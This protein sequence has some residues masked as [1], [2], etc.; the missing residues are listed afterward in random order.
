MNKTKKGNNAERE[1]KQYLEALGL[2]VEQAKSQIVMIGKNKFFRRSYDFWNLFDLIALGQSWLRLIQVKS[3]ISDV[4]RAKKLITKFVNEN[5]C[6]YTSVEIW[7][8]VNGK[9]DKRGAGFRI[10]TFNSHWQE[11]EFVKL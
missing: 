7:L 2:P 5:P 4:S 1:A 6:R 9:K 8:R 3:N 11:I 10:W